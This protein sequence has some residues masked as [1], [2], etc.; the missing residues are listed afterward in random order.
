MASTRR[1]ILPTVL[2]GLYLIPAA[3]PFY[4]ILKSALERPEDVYNPHLLPRGFSL[5]NFAEL[6]HSTSFATNALNSLQVALISSILVVCCSALGGYALARG[7]LPHKALIAKVV[8]FSY[9]FPEVLLGIPFF[10]MFQKMGLINSLGGLA[11][12][13]I[14]LSLPFGL[15]LMWQFYQSLPQSYEEAAEIDGASRFQVFLLVMVPLSLPALAAV[16]IFA[17]AASWNDYVLG[18]MLIR[19]DKNFTLPIAMSLFV[20]QTELNWAVIQA[21]NFLLAVPG[22][23]LVLFGRKYLVRGFQ[24]SGLAN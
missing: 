4:W 9:M 15:W 17:F 19:D 3:F 14:T 18:L 16:F 2:I 6:I 1:S 22:L 11:V 12:A 8:L 21:A 5:N 13:H 10:A 24:T 23:L 20:Q 7:N